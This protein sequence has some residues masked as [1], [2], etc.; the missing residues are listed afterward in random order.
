MPRARSNSTSPVSATSHDKSSGTDPQLA[1]KKDPT[2]S[3]RNEAASKKLAERFD[4]LNQAIALA[5]QRIKQLK[6]ARAVWVYY[7]PQSDDPLGGPPCSYELLGIDKVNNQWR[8][9]HALDHDHTD[10]GPWGVQP[11][12]ECPI[13]IRVRAVS[14]LQD[15]RLR[16]V[17]ANEKF[18]PEVENAIA[19]VLNFCEGGQS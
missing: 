10:D 15:L 13:E 11:L 4:S 17:E 5:E 3:Q 8:L 6:P 2:L 18:I 1:S 19:E 12:V 9:V 7:N 16:V 14:H